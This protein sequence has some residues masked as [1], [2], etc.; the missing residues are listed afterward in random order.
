MRNLL[1]ASVVALM[2]LA[3]AVWAQQGAQ[4]IVFVQVEAHP[5]LQTAQTRAR[6]VSDRLPDVN[7]FSLGGGWYGIA[8]GPYRRDDAQQVLNVYRA[9]GRI[10]TD[11]YIAEAGAYGNQFWPVGANVLNRGTVTV[12]DSTQTAEVTATPEPTP[13]PEPQVSDETPAEA[14]R[15]EQLLSADER[16][17][18]QIA[19][20]WAGFYNS[21]IDG[22]FGPGTRQSM[23][24][25]QAAKGFEATGIL[26]TKQRRVLMDMYNAPLIS[27]GMAERTD[28]GAGIRL[29]IPAGAVKFA[30]YEPPFAH[31]DSTTA[32][33][34]RLL[35][36]SQPGD[37]KTLFGLYD[38][39]Q[40]LEIVPLNGPRERSN[41]SFVLE[42][43]NGRI[44]SYTEA[45]LEDGQI[46]GFTLIWPA[47]DEDR[48]TRVLALMRQSFTSTEGVL[49]PMA[50]GDAVQSIDLVSGLTIRKPRLSR[51][52]FYVDQAG[53]VVTTA[54][55]VRGCTRVTLDK[56]YRA[57]VAGSDEALGVAVLRPT[58]QL[59]PPSVARFAQSSPRLKSDITVAGYSYEGALGAPTLTFGKIEDVKGLRGEPDLARLALSPEAG[60]AGGPVLDA[61]GAVLGMLLP[62]AEGDRQLPGDVSFAVSA[63]ALGTVLNKL[64]LSAAVLQASARAT[65]NDLLQKATGMTVLVSCW[66]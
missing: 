5:D 44:V 49:D 33:G 34:I 14:R 28:A 58:D 59:A 15:S 61:A 30:R 40:T 8:L 7:G 57:E 22:A 9:E 60:D 48:R 21:G 18:L 19:L 25:W 47:G 10:P 46:K 38:I 35:L 3:T 23:A 66:D 11:A 32:D 45:A 64:G 16:K 6:F 51:S 53:T 29:Q 42:G 65:P 26:T 24:D 41:S 43:R 4:D 31:Y 56:T 55:A 2:S 37:Q 36:I 63:A 1:I 50:G 17:E 39:L 13:E 62:R 27:V 12:P 52:G 20:Q 54:E